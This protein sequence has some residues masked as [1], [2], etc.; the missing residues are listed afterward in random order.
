[1]TIRRNKLYLGG[2]S[3]EELTRKFGSPLYVYEEKILKEKY[4]ELSRAITYAR[5]RIFYACKANTNPE[6]MKILGR[7]K[8][9]IEAV[10]LGEVAIARRAGFMPKDIIFTGDNLTLPE[11]EALVKQN[12]LI[13]ADSLGQIE[14]IGRLNPGGKISIRVNQGIGAGMHNHVITGGP[15][16]KFGIYLDQLNTAKKLAQRYNLKIAGVMQHIGSGILDEKIYLTAM[17]AL[18]KVARQFP[19]LEFIDVGGGLGVAYKSEQKKLD[20]VSLGAK[21][22]REFSEFAQTYGKEI[23]LYFEPGRFLVAE[24]GVLLA[25]VAEIKENKFHT[26]VG[27]NSGMH[28]LI[29]PAMYGSYH[30]ILNASRV[31]GKAKK[32]EIVGNI[33]ESSD[34]FAHERKITMPKEGEIL[35]ILNAGAY[36]YSMS[37]N[38]NSHPRPAEILVDKGKARII[39][40]REKI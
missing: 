23:S 9:G 3:A 29:R 21:I 2:I 10:S 14:K 25:T 6:I 30:E 27:L 37:S 11:L 38:Y 26:F 17:R 34:F 12:I 4:L 5:T 40:R 8:T 24:A 19:D 28:H 22:S 15:D 7:L 32:V 35:A 1:M 39:R 13:S 33:C 18:L 16:S 36:G 31:R 20:L